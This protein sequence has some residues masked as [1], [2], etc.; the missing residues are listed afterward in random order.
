M[1]FF[2]LANSTWAIWRGRAD[3]LGVND[4]Q[5]IGRQEALKRQ[6]ASVWDL[7]TLQQETSL[8]QSHSPP[9]LSLPVLPENTDLKR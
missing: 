1:S 6:Q 2:A 8:L 4:Q 7:S 3:D 9:L 5:L